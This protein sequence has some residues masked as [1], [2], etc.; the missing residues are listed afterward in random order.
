VF[1]E[2]SL[3]GEIRRVPHHERRV[4]TSDEMGFH[5]IIGPRSAAE[6]PKGFA[7]VGTVAEA[8]RSVFAGG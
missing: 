8:V 7:A 5:R 4:R 6:G 2:V 3:A 1:G